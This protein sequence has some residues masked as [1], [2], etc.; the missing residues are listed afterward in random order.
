MW[1]FLSE[2]FYS[3][4]RTNDLPPGHL[5]V[6]ARRG[7]DLEK[8]AGRGCQAHRRARLPVPCHCAGAGGCRGRGAR[9]DR[10]PVRQLQGQRRRP[11]AARCLPQRLA[12]WRVSSVRRLTAG[13]SARVEEGMVIKATPR[14]AIIATPEPPRVPFETRSLTTKCESCAMIETLSAAAKLI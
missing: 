1:L 4:V 2:S 9:G 12:R 6:R 14:V 7:G 5:L 10:H 3:I 8:L 11:G 13:G